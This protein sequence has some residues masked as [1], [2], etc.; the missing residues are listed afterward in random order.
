MNSSNSA[1]EFATKLKTRNYFGNADISTSEGKSEALSYAKGI[2]A[3]LKKFSIIEVTIDSLKGAYDYGKKHYLKLG[4]GLL[5]T[6][7]FAFWYY[8]KKYK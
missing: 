3:K 7:A 6:T 2:L 5:I 8:K 4:L 1:E